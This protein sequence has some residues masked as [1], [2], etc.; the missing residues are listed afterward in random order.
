MAE[1]HRRNEEDGLARTDFWTTYLRIGFVVMAIE[2][3]AA[4]A[5]FATSPGLAHRA[6]L[7]SLSTATLLA[8]VAIV[9]V[10]GWMATRPWRARLSFLAALASGLVLTA[11]CAMDGG[12]DSPLVFL[13]VLPVLNAGLALGV[14][15]VVACGIAGSAEL[16][17]LALTDPH[18]T[19]SDNKLIL[20]FSLI[21]GATA[22]AI[23]Y[24]SARGRLEAADT[25]DRAELARLAETDSLT[26]CLNHRAFYSRL[27]AE[28]DR[29][30]RYGSDLSLMV[31]DVDL[32]KDFNDAHGHRAGDEALASL[33]SVLRGAAR[34]S[35]IVGRIGGDEFAVVLPSTA[36]D[37]AGI[38]ADRMVQLVHGSG[39]GLDVS[40]GVAEADRT[41]LSVARFFGDADA[42]LYRAKALGRGRSVVAD[43][44]AGGRPSAQVD[45]IQASPTRQADYELLASEAR[46]TRRDWAQSV[47]RMEAMLDVAPFGVCFVDLDFRVQL[48]NAVFAQ[49]NGASAEAQVGRRVDQ[50]VPSLW[51]QLESAYLHVL[52]TGDPL[53][54]GPA[55]SDTVSAPGQTRYWL[56]SLFPVRVGDSITGLGVL[57][58]DVTD[59]MALARTEETLV[60]RMA[61]ALA[62]TVEERDPYTAGHEERV[63]AIATA[64][65][66]DLG[67]DDADV[68]RLNL[69]SRV[70]DL[71]K[72]RIPAEILSRP[73][74]LNDGEMALVR[75]HSQTG[76]DILRSAGFP[77]ELSLIVL[78]HHERLDGSGYPGN[79]RGDR[80]CAGAKVLAVADVAEAMTSPR[81]YRSSLPP[82]AAVAELQEGR[83]RLYDSEA[84]DAYVRLLSLAGR[85]GSFA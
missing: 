1:T 27:E 18:V 81:P 65:A 62:A 39:L 70:H 13:G 35:D 21:A 9:P 84:V 64:M 78:Q 74:R 19:S 50:L 8:A 68:A 2:A 76:Y 72:I 53:V 7:L 48:I 30:A 11:A 3:A 45:P 51:P 40:I 57:G 59:R 73:G 25:A 46:R 77:E 69:A 29:V 52:R 10:T 14:A 41:A 6:A 80:I 12:I 5:Y 75:Q 17:L 83:G 33:G 56:A 37:V 22:L 15:Q 82:E 20:F 32:F 63:A 58:V 85:A 16:G 4:V 36:A 26:G 34:R 42:A 24:A 23:V 61:A 79:L 55:V 54:L 60:E 67:W 49:V 47:A 44:A 31:L 43:E 28:V 38:T 71:G 66:V